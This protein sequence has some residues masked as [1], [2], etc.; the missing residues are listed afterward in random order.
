MNPTELFQGLNELF[1]VKVCFHNCQL[2]SLF[3]VCLSSKHMLKTQEI[4]LEMQNSFAVK[5]VL[6]PRQGH[7]W[8]PLSLSLYTC[9]LPCST[10][11]LEAHPAGT[12]SQK[13]GRRKKKEVDIVSF[14]FGRLTCVE[15]NY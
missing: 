13:Q 8:L 3:L 1:L 7:P 14:N 4:P 2:L 11:A 6:P 15:I 9:W 10:N 5:F 12:L